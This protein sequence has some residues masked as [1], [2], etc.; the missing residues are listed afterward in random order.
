MWPP[1]EL[2]DQIEPTTIFYSRDTPRTAVREYTAGDVGAGEVYPGWWRWV[3]T[4]RGI[5]GTNHPLVLR[6]V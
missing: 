5:P 3:G 4:R 1:S 6:P 2:V